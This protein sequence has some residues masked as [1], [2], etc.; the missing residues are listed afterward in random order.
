MGQV[1]QLWTISGNIGVT[2]QLVLGVM[3]LTNV[4]LTND[5]AWRA[6]LSAHDQQACG[7]RKAQKLLLGGMV[8]IPRVMMHNIE[9]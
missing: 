9:T 3:H 5:V 4:A 6:S 2:L 8:M 1:P 7:V